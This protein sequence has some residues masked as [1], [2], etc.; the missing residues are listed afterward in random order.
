MPAEFS[1]HADPDELA[2]QSVAAAFHAD[3]GKGGGKGA[4]SSRSAVSAASPRGKASRGGQ[5]AGQPRR[6]AFRRS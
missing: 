3:E 2:A 6:Y 5:S 4:R 1:V